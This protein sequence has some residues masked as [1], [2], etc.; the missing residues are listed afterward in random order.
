MTNLSSEEIIQIKDY[1][2]ETLMEEYIYDRLLAENMVDNS[3]FM[4]L[5]QNNPEYVL[6][7]DFG[8]W[9][10]YIKNKVK[11]NI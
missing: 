10:E 6:H 11:Y 7:Y 2:V 4:V 5:L 8:Y 3:N 9:A 1:I